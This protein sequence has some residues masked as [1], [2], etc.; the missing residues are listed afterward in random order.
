[1]KFRFLCLAY[2]FL[3]PFSGSGQK[4]QSAVWYYGEFQKISFLTSPISIEKVFF[5][6]RWGTASVCD[7]NG[8]YLFSCDGLQARDHRDS[9]MPNGLIL[10]PL[11]D[12]PCT[13]CI[14]Q[15]GGNLII[16]FTDAPNLY[17]LYVIQSWPDLTVF[18]G[19]GVL[20]HRIVDM[21]LNEGLG[22]LLPFPNYKETAWNKVA[23]Q[24]TCALHANGKDTWLI[25]RKRD[26][27][28]L[29]AWLVSDT[30]FSQVVYS[31]T[32]SPV[33]NPNIV[34]LSNFIPG[35]DAQI[36]TSPDSRMLFVPRRTYGFPYHELYR[37]NNETG[38]FSDPIFIKDSTN[39]APNFYI[40]GF[41]D[42]CFSPDS[43]KL[44]TGL[45]TR[46]KPQSS[47]QTNVGFG[48]LWQYDVSQYDSLAIAQSKVFIGRFGRVNPNKWVRPPAPRMQLA[49]DGK[50]YISPGTSSLGDSFLSVMN[51]PNSPGY[52]CNIAWRK[53]KLISRNGAFFPTLNQTFIRNAGIFQVQAN[54]RKICVGDTL[55]L[56]G[57]GAGAE[58][59]QWQTSVGFPAGVLDTLTTLRFAVKPEMV[60]THTF[61]CFGIGRCMAKDSFVVVE[62]LPA[63][64]KPILTTVR[65]PV[66]CKGDTAL[67]VLQNAIAGYHYQWNTGDTTTSI[68]VDSTG[69]YFL[70][71]SVTNRGCVL[72][73]SDTVSLVFN[74][75]VVPEVPVLVSPALVEICEGQKTQLTVGS[76]QLTV[77]YK[78]S[79]GAEGDSILVD[80][81]QFT[82]YSE[83]VEGCTSA[84]SD[85]VEV[86]MYSYPKPK[87]VDVDSVLNLT[88]LENQ[89]YCV[90]GLPGSTFSFSIQN[91]TVV[92]SS[93]DCVTINWMPGNIQRSLKVTETRKEADC[94]SSASQNLLYRSNLQIPSLITPN[95]DG[96]N[97]AFVIQD[98]E[99]YTSHR[100]KIFDRWGKRVVD[101]TDYKQ[102]W[103]GESGIYF[104]NLVVDGK[105]FVG[106]VSVAE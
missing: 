25:G 97:D 31:K 42:G 67:I 43:R 40:N 64:P 54:K 48:T 69:S 33:R 2:L 29:I 52:Q 79:N 17:H 23:N 92:D 3:L 71:S 47:D 6:G 46:T 36:K 13:D 66:P 102:D 59:F 24:L 1:M 98:L 50:I 53:H 38:A 91:G 27:D 18:G 55:D 81:G 14:N 95:N 9:I 16:P 41:P 65:K 99:F 58:H 96:H 12:T 35:F 100:L 83:T 10:N 32:N 105:K 15:A 7:S 75:A 5:D 73:G 56:S 61:T 51:C 89:N 57:Y 94:Q 37:F 44:Y 49:M 20:C 39:T 26:T 104:Y 19:Q 93:E 82:V 106:W 70:N 45:G 62:V 63:P 87:F 72:K 103:K 90:A 88:K 68:R 30:G 76:E 11:D 78:W 85:T 101:T 34:S 8:N 21:E 22:A 77:K 74:P 4:K 86:K 80:G 84:S 60:G 28:T